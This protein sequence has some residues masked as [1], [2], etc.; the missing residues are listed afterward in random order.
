[1]LPFFHITS[2]DCWDRVSFYVIYAV[3]VFITLAVAA[4]SI[5]L[6]LVGSTDTR[7][8]VIKTVTLVF[9]VA[10]PIISLV[11]LSLWN[12]TRVGDVFFLTADLT[13]Q[14]NGT[15]YL[16]VALANIIFVLLFVF[17][18]PVF[19]FIYVYRYRD[20]LEDESVRARIGHFYNSYQGL[21]T[22]CLAKHL[23]TILCVSL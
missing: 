19:S 7:N 3:G 17:G 15:Q 23:Y 20:Q 12:C 14:C 5:R 11:S 4:I 21:H 22:S 2:F 13:I 16:S 1:M 18:W 10:Y 6:F 9:T 8:T